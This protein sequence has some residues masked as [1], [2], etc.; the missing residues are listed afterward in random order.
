MYKFMKIVPFPEQLFY[1]DRMVGY[2][3]EPKILVQVER[4]KGDS[5]SVRVTFQT[6]V[7]EVSQCNHAT[8]IRKKVSVSVNSILDGNSNEVTKRVISRM[9]ESYQRLPYRL[10]NEIEIM[11]NE[12]LSEVIRT[13]KDDKL[14]FWLG[15]E[16]YS[17]V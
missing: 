2:E 16:E 4:E 12:Q 9:T 17:K 5:N 13:L 15:N 8:T 11:L 10:Q 14:F 7:K 3:Q 6:I 1:M